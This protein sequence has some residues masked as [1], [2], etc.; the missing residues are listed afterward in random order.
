MTMCGQSRRQ[1]PKRGRA[2]PAYYVG[3]LI[4]YYLNPLIANDYST[5]FYSFARIIV[6]DVDD[7]LLAY[8][9]LP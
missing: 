9:A 3:F 2:D 6:D 4:Y 1:Q 5:L 7:S 8:P